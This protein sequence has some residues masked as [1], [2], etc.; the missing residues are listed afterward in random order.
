MSKDG[1]NTSSNTSATTNNKDAI[2]RLKAVQ[3]KLWAIMGLKMATDRLRD[4]GYDVVVHTESGSGTDSGTGKNDS[5]TVT[6]KVNLKINFDFD[7]GT[8]NGKDILAAQNELQEQI[9]KLEGKSK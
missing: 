1:L 4:L 9:A 3:E 8:V 2:K 6:I 5:G 7:S